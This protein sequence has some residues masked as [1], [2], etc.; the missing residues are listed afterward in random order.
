MNV[1]RAKCVSSVARHARRAQRQEALLAVVRELA[2]EVVVGIHDP[3]VLFRIVGADLDVVR[4]SPDLVPLRPVFD[5]LAV[6]IEH[7]NDVIPAP[8]DAR[9]A[10]VPIASVGA[11]GIPRHSGGVG[12]AAA[13][14][15][16]AGG[17]AQRHALPTGNLMLG[18]ISGSQ[19]VL[20]FFGSTGSKPFCAT[21]TRSGVLGKNIGR[22]REGPPLQV[23]K[24]LR[25]RFRPILHRIVR[26]ENVLPA[27]LSGNGREPF[28]GR[29]L[30]PVPAQCP[31]GCSPG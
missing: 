31:S 13:A 6:A 17:L 3:D 26:A 24:A 29:L 10:L 19:V 21:N 11:I 27:L 16:G 7:D 18:P 4:P 1:G 8:I 28:S 25:Q 15:G 30:L 22:L 12:N 9:P 5:H 20:R 14:R 23:G 2:D